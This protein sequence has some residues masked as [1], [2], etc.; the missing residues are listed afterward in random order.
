MTNANL[1]A[2]KGSWLFRCGQVACAVVG[3]LSLLASEL[4]DATNTPTGRAKRL[5]PVTDRTGPSLHTNQ[6]MW[7]WYGWAAAII[8]KG[9]HAG[10]FAGTG[11]KLWAGPAGD[12]EV[13]HERGRVSADWLHFLHAWTFFRSFLNYANLL[14]AGKHKGHRG[15]LE[16]QMNLRQCGSFSGYLPYFETSKPANVTLLYNRGSLV[17]GVK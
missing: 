16:D 4:L 7:L 6:I 17:Q 9:R 15:C 2:K 8:Q 12:G 10:R 1:T 13:R 11:G 5:M 14:V 3:C